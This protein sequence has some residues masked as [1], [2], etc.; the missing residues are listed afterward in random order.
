[1]GAGWGVFAFG[2]RRHRVRFK[3][4]SWAAR[5]LDDG[6][7]IVQQALTGKARQS[8][9]GMSYG[10]W[11]TRGFSS[12]LDRLSRPL[13]LLNSRLACHMVLFVL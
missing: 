2:A 13:I 5:Y 10:F 7:K 12:K 3:S 8:P 6:D 11:T 9:E 1:M 4:F